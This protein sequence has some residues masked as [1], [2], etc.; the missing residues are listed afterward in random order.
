MIDFSW[1][2]TEVTPQ[3]LLSALHTIQ[4]THSITAADLTGDWVPAQTYI[5]WAESS[6]QLNNEFGWDAAL[7]YSKRAVCRHIDA[8]MVNNHL[9]SFLGRP[10][11][12]KFAALTRLGLNAPDILH[13]L[14]IG[15]RNDIEHIYQRASRQEASH[16]VQLAKLFVPTDDPFAQDFAMISFGWSVSHRAEFGPNIDRFEFRLEP[17]H[18]P[19]LLIDTCERDHVAMILRPKAQELLSCKLK[20]FSLDEAIEM[21]LK[22]RTQI[23]RGGGISTYKPALMKRM[24][25]ELKL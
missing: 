14:I 16:A 12:A 9:G 8:M 1:S 19:Q 15:P 2:R 4:P 23:G 3:D 6:V 20:D 7:S 24:K 11:P 18:H 10:Y 21:A 5:S 13:D 25:A 17:H 22:I